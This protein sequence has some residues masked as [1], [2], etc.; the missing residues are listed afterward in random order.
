MRDWFIFDGIP[1]TD[2]GAYIANS[3]LFDAPERDVEAVEIPGRN[4]NLYFDNGRYRNFEA[5]LSVYIP[6]RMH[7]NVPA[8]RAFLMSK[9][10]YCRYEDTMHINEFRLARFMG[11]FVVSQS[12]RVGAAMELTFDC[13]PQRFLK[14]GEQPI[15]ITSTMTIN[16]PTLYNARPLIRCYGTGGT[17]TVG[18]ISITVSGCTEYVDID[19]DLMESY[20]GDVSRNSTTEL[21]NGEFPVLPPGETAIGVSGFSRIEITPRWYTI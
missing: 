4:G 14:G 21:S 10:G 15:T 13:K 17:I 7:E 19:C 20:E 18:D 1:S 16:N 12:D 5:V 9:V 6:R 2:F 11:E 3:N 8:L